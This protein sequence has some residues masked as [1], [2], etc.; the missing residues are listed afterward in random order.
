MDTKEKY[1]DECRQIQQNS[2]YTAEAHHHLANWNRT[3]AYLFQI[4]PATVAAI[5][6]VL[7]AAYVKPNSWLWITV[8]ASVV[9]AVAGILDPNKKYQDHLGAAKSFTA[10]KHDARFLHEAKSERMSDEAFAVGVENLHEKYNELMKLVPATGDQSFKKAQKMI[11]L[12]VHEPDW[13]PDGK[14]K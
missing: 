14:I 7:V 9:S 4:V 3:L 2:T 8:V 11:N 5:T 12:G 1:K 10:I 6:G 13:T